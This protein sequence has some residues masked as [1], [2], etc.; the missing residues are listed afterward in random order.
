ML[1]ITLLETLRTRV[2]IPTTVEPIS[3]IGLEELKG[4]FSTIGIN[5][6][7][8]EQAAIA[9]KYKSFVQ[10]PTGLINRLFDREPYPT[11]R[12]D[13]SGPISAGSSWQ[14]AVLIA[15]ALRANDDSLA[16]E[17]N[18]SAALVWATGE[19]KSDLTVAG[20]GNVSDKLR[21]SKSLFEQSLAGG[22]RIFVFLPSENDKDVDPDIEEW[23][24]ARDIKVN[25]VG[26]LDDVF[27]TLTLPKVA[28]AAS[29]PK[30][31]R[32]HW[33]GNPYRG[34]EAYLQEHREIFFGRGR[35][36]E[37]AIEHLRTA[38]ARYRPFLL[39]HGQSGVGKSSLARAGLVGDI[40]E[41][42]GDDKFFK[43]AVVT[44]SEGGPDPVL[45]LCR[46]LRQLLSEPAD[47][48]EGL[49][50]SHQALDLLV[51][52]QRKLDFATSKPRALLIIDQLEE[53]FDPSIAAGQPEIFGELI[54]K[55]VSSRQIW[56]IATIRSDIL[57]QLDRSPSLARLANTERVYRLDRPSRYELSEIIISPLTLSGKTFS[58]RLIPEQ[59]A[60]IA[61]QSPDSLPLL[62]TVLFRYYEHAGQENQLTADALRRIGGFEGAVG[63]WA[64]DVRERMVSA[65][66][67]S[68]E[69]DRILVSLIRIEPE[70]RRPLSRSLAIHRNTL[71][72][73]NKEKIIS[74]LIEARLV[75]TFGAADGPRVRLAHE[76]LTSHWPHLVMLAERLSSAIAVRDDLEQRAKAWLLSERDSSELLHG[77]DRIN[78][79][80]HFLNESLVTFDASVIPFVEASHALAAADEEKAQLLRNAEIE[81]V[82]LE[83]DIAYHRAQSSRKVAKIVLIASVI[84]AI[85]ALFAFIQRNAAQTANHLAQTRLENERVANSEL[86]AEK[87]LRVKPTNLEDARSALLTILPREVHSK[88][89]M[90]E[91]VRKALVSVG[92]QDTA[93]L[94]LKSTGDVKD[95]VFSR[96]GS[97]LLVTSRFSSK[98]WDLATGALLRELPMDLCGRIEFNHDGS[99]VL[100]TSDNRVDLV[101]VDQDTFLPLDIGSNSSRCPPA[102]YTADGLRV[103]VA[104]NSQLT[105]FN[106]GSGSRISSVAISEDP[107]DFTYFSDTQ[108]ALLYF[109]RGDRNR[110]DLVNP[111]T[112]QTSVTIPLSPE[113][114]ATLLEELTVKFNIDGTLI[115]ISAPTFGLWESATGAPV[116]LANSEQASANNIQFS[117]D[118]ERLLVVYKNLILKLWNLETKELIRSLPAT[119]GSLSLERVA[120]SSFSDLIFV[121]ERNGF[122]NQTEI[123][124]GRPYPNLMALSPDSQ[125]LFIA[126]KDQVLVWD[127][128]DRSKDLSTHFVGCIGLCK[129]SP[130]SRYYT[131]RIRQGV[132]DMNVATLFPGGEPYVANMLDFMTEEERAAYSDS[133]EAAPYEVEDA[134][135]SNDHLAVCSSSGLIGIWKHSTQ[136]VIWSGRAESCKFSFSANGQLFTYFEPDNKIRVLETRGWSELWHQTIETRGDVSVQFRPDSTDLIVEDSGLFRIFDGNTGLNR[137]TFDKGALK[138][139]TLEYVGADLYEVR[140]QNDGL[141]L[142]LFADEREKSS[143]NPGS[144]TIRFGKSPASSWKASPNGEYISVTANGSETAIYRLKSGE[145]VDTLR[146]GFNF[147]EFSPDSRRYISTRD[148]RFTVSVRDVLTGTS[149]YEQELTSS[150]GESAVH[151]ST[152]NNYL[153]IFTR[154]D[155]MGKV[156]LSP[157]VVP[158]ELVKLFRLRNLNTAVVS[159]DEGIRA[160]SCESTQLVPVERSE[161]VSMSAFQSDRYWDA[162]DVCR[163]ADV[164]NHTVTQAAL[165]DRVHLHNRYYLGE[166]KKRLASFGEELVDTQQ[167]LLADYEQLYGDITGRYRAREIYGKLND[168]GNQ[169]A[170]LS[171]AW[172]NWIG[173]G[174]PQDHLKA[175]EMWKNLAVDGNPFAHERLGWLYE[176]GRG[177]T[178]QDVGAAFHHYAL[179]ADLFDR[180]GLSALGENARYRRA[181]LS[182]SAPNVADRP[183]T[184]D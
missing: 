51:R 169:T 184:P 18:A 127:N 141:Y 79:A 24:G 86:I 29:K 30:V 64:E 6:K 104:N 182:R 23:L 103:L 160:I 89:D 31:S 40:Q 117:P 111:T 27:S 13:I 52:L 68:D 11:Y 46:G 101:G 26:H 16:F 45:S 21:N 110:V 177:S 152:D 20:V 83:R 131:S 93:R 49:D 3:I 41:L 43:T 125:W 163:D 130:D 73:S 48:I 7:T 159:N 133:G 87:A 176:L 171:L 128:V 22:K 38:A 33:V 108:I 109:R 175:V 37:E 158:E 36:R 62:Q 92:A 77:T 69:I 39:I 84:L 97:R 183:V 121:M 147:I 5:K 17:P 14:L 44:P 90:S 63:F 138:G 1:G 76:I 70:T 126:H 65:G 173:A 122:D 32:P 168:K 50:P 124:R 58:D 60:D 180:K 119:A 59:F 155:G 105:F 42:A 174:G 82:R 85:V 88:S 106:A 181:N 144:Q 12:L 34:L 10:Q 156:E 54:E 167:L 172:M 67:P 95:V 179:A 72:P 94:V 81:N 135:L 165:R 136:E 107:K 75:S 134:A 35:A 96:D 132:Y 118:G 71:P 15:H 162:L 98:I 123:Q 146:T 178:Q 142:R 100:L 99:Q 148:V 47:E 61:A 137:T 153:Y 120:I 55:I 2:V 113:R 139:S 102:H 9:Q 143:A 151:F 74:A 19:V 57:G 112:A 91:A 145:I 78:A 166:I 149:L 80:D 56:L 25:F 170:K 114:S 4:G 164:A 140:N 129:F 116:S 161:S 28:Q 66:L 150:A 53:I 8:T 115:A 154:F 157:E